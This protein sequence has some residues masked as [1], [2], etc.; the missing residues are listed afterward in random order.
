LDEAS[1]IIRLGLMALDHLRADHV[2]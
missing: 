1:D 2:E